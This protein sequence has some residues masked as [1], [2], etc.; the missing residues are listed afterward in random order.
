MENKDLLHVAEIVSKEKELP[1]DVVLEALETGIEVSILRDLPEGATVSVTIDNKTG[2]VRAYR[3]F[4][5]VDSIT[6][7]ESEMLKTEIDDEFVFEDVAYEV[8]PF[9]MDR[10]KFSITKQ[11]ALQR[12]N[13]ESKEAKINDL[14]K[15]TVKLFTGTVKVFTNNQYIVDLFGIEMIIP[16]KN[17]M[18]NDR[19]K[20]GDKISFVIEK[21][22]EKFVGSRISKEFVKEIFKKEVHQIEDNEIEIV[23][24]ARIPGFKSKVVLKSN[25][26]NIDPIKT[27]I[28]VRHNHI[29]NIHTMMDGEYVDMI[30][31]SDDLPKMIVKLFEP[32][33]VTNILIDEENG[34][35]D[36]SV[37]DNEKAKAIGV[38]GKNIFLIKELLE[39][40]VN[41]F[42]ESEW[43]ENNSQQKESLVKMFCFGLDCDEDISMSIVENGYS[44]IEEV[45]YV[46]LVEFKEIGFEDD[47]VTELRERAKAI[48]SDE[49]KMKAIGG[50]ESLFSLGFTMEEVKKLNAENIFNKQDLADLSKF[51]LLD[52]LPEIEE[53][54]ACNLVMSARK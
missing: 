3:T 27:C 47:L 31:Y 23:S 50:S 10:K 17:L 5:L 9:N 45:A 7:I 22:N 12:I 39:K 51:E 14:L 40:S 29:K 16:K 19:F 33:N 53:E 24:I 48:F 32:V 20:S 49:D 6:S 44:S 4:N 13:K 35:I 25:N 26:E 30:E 15:D 46:P 11:I 18:P 43:E 42:S 28:G 8:I 52:I 37:P 2:E 36:V 38:S 34:T 54:T 21:E 1:V 41:I